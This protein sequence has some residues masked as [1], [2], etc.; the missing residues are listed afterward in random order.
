MA[1]QRD[2]PYGAYNFQI[3]IEGSTS[4]GFCEVSGLSVEIAVIAYRN[5]NDRANSV[6]KLPGLHRAGNVTFKRG[7]IGDT[8]LFGWLR[9]AAQGDT[10]AA[11]SVVVTLLDEARVPVMRWLLVRAWPVQWEASALNATGNEV[12]IE[13]LTLACDSI[14]ID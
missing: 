7:I 13:S 12:A 11:R 8:S 9:S 2:N 6:R 3:E 10:A 14:E 5:G 4:A 1:T